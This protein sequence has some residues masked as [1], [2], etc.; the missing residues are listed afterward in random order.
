MSKNTVILAVVGVVV[1]SLVGLVFMSEQTQAPSTIIVKSNHAS[2]NKLPDLSVSYTLA[3]SNKTMYSMVV[4]SS[5][6]EGQAVL[7]QGKACNTMNSTITLLPKGQT[8]DKK[9]V[10][11]LTDGRQVLEPMTMSTLMACEPTTPQTDDTALNAVIND[12]A[13]SLQS[14]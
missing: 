1:V 7:V 10:K 6:T 14:Y 12:L 3:E 13:A 2:S 11:T 9:V 8:T 5:I 4:S